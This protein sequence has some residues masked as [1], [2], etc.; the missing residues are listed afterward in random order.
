MT[1]CVTLIVL[2]TK[3]DAQSYKLVT[4]SQTNLATLATINVPSEF[5]TKFQREVPL[6]IP[7]VPLKHSV[8]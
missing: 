7:R 6:D 5:G 2:Y 8:G 4:V 3:V 1:R